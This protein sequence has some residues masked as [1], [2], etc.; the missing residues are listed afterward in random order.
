MCLLSPPPLVPQEAR[1]RMLLRWQVGVADEDKVL[2]TAW[3]GV[4]SRQRGI[5]CFRFKRARAALSVLTAHAHTHAPPATKQRNTH[6]RLPH[7]AET[8]EA[9]GGAG[10]RPGGGGGVWVSAGVRA[11]DTV[12]GK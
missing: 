3:H 5:V 7:N 6:T 1:E 9:L 12:H 2:D 11:H 4:C 10:A 8:Q